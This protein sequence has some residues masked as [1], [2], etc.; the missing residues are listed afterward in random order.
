MGENVT[1]NPSCTKGIYKP[2]MCQ[3]CQQINAIPGKPFFCFA[4]SHVKRFDRL[5]WSNYPKCAEENCPFCHPEKLE[6]EGTLTYD[7]ET[8]WGTIRVSLNNDPDLNE[9]QK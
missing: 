6:G 3:F 4:Y 9:E 2:P 1:S 5:H 7:I 8:P